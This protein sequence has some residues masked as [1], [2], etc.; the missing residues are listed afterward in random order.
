M[1]TTTPKEERTADVCTI[2][3]KTMD[4]VDLG[5]GKKL[6][7]HYCLVCRYVFILW[8]NMF[9]MYWSGT[10]GPARRLTSLLGAS[11]A[12]ARI[13]QGM[14]FVSFINWDMF[15]DNL[16]GAKT[17]SKSTKLNAPNWGLLCMPG[18]SILHIW[19]LSCMLMARS[20]KLICL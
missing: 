17:T 16:K 3:A 5:T 11:P 19:T 4:H 2:F 8:H 7:G 15:S 14:T 13:S 1:H 10:M 12:Y 6:T 20:Y 18:P 9:V